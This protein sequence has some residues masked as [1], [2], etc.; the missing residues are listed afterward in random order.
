M[1]HLLISFALTLILT[2]PALATPLIQAIKIHNFPLANAL[3]KHNQRV[4]EADDAGATPLHWAAAIGWEE[5]IEK[6]LGLGAPIDCTTAADET[7]LHWAVWHLKMS[8]VRLL[9]KCNANPN[10]PS[11]DGWTP[12]HVAAVR[13]HIPIAQALIT[14]GANRALKDARGR[15]AVYLTS[16]ESVIDG[17][18]RF[19]VPETK[20]RSSLVGRLRKSTKVKF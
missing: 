12:L 4:F 15:T 7:P 14:A 2:P 6:L 19:E 1:R 9:L 17:I 18:M 20:R 16:V 10:S 11:L 5:M 3:V 8:M 13:G